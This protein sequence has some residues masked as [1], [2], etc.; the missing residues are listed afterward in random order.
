[1]L[2]NSI[3]LHNAVVQ[4]TL[5]SVGEYQKSYESYNHE[6]SATEKETTEKTGS[7]SLLDCEEMWGGFAASL[8]AVAFYVLC[9]D[10]IGFWGNVLYFFVQCICAFM[11]FFY[12]IDDNKEIRKVAFILGMI[13]LIIYFPPM[14][15]ACQQLYYLAY[16]LC[17]IWVDGT[18]LTPKQEYL[19]YNQLGWLIF[20]GISL[21]MD[22]VLDFLYYKKGNFLFP[23]C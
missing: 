18:C 16:P 17:T 9:W 11:T 5:R 13:S 23:K 14:I 3:V 20:L 4:S 22:L 6:T 10:E 7:Y 2:G 1:M 12:K 8:L 15:K 19:D 21:L